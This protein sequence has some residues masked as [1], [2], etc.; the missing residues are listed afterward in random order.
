MA[1]S[2]PARNLDQRP[3]NESVHQVNLDNQGI[4][5]QAELGQDLEAKI[6][7][8]DFESLIW[9]GMTMINQKCPAIHLPPKRSHRQGDHL[10]I[11]HLNQLNLVGPPLERVNRHR[12]VDDTKEA[13]VTFPTHDNL[14]LKLHPLLPDVGLVL[15]PGIARW[16]DH[17]RVVHN[18][19]PCHLLWYLPLIP[20]K[21]KCP[22]ECP[23]GIEPRVIETSF[24]HNGH[25]ISL[26]ATEKSMTRT[27]SNPRPDSPRRLQLCHPMDDS[28]AVAICHD[29][30]E[31]NAIG[32]LTLRVPLYYINSL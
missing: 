21:E 15:M 19:V 18:G 11:L 5:R 17:R 27:K 6:D 1:T 8:A 26:V 12:Q 20:S 31:S 4:L 22:A 7:A 25:R 9:L 10:L 30:Q 13:V 3:G 32:L 23:M 28:K 2:N 29:R 24:R 14:R 16:W